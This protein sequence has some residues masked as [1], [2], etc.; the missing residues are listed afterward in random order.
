MKLA[1]VA[2]CMLL[3]AM[4]AASARDRDNLPGSSIALEYSLHHDALRPGESV[5][6]LACVTN[7][8]SSSTRAV[9]PGDAFTFDFRRGTLG[10]TCEGVTVHSPGAEL[11]PSDFT[12][13]ITGGSLTLTYTG[14][15]APWPHGD[16]ACARVSFTAP[17]EPTTV[18][19]RQVVRNSGAFSHA[20]PS[21]ILLAVADGLGSVGPQG[22]PGPAG[23]SGPEGPSGV[24]GPSGPPGPQGA[25]GPLGGSGIGSHAYA[26]STDLAF[27]VQNEPAVLIPGL[28]VTI[29][30]E[31]GS[32]LL[33]M[34]DAIAWNS[35]DC[36]AAGGG[37]AEAYLQLEVDGVV[38]PETTGSAF[39][40]TWRSQA[41]AAGS[42]QVRILM[43]APPE[44]PFDHDPTYCYGSSS[45]YSGLQSRLA[46]LE[47]RAP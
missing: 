45:V 6:L 47:L 32:G 17:L 43:W 8:N 35:G 29:T 34:L 25:P 44:H 14:S 12:C 4:S 46:V 20:Q 24:A 16:A 9:A 1:T 11:G 18:L 22:P 28:D 33:V 38:V 7:L 10:A 15:G 23:P 5:M 30:V 40:I 31:G 19:T 36:P 27:A 3:F 41:L 26:A 13:A 21:A 42:H 2:A 39:N 37:G